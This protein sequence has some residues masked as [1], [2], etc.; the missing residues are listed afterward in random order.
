MWKAKCAGYPA[1]VVRS[2]LNCVEYG[3]E[4][5]GHNIKNYLES[6]NHCDDSRMWTQWEPERR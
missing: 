4:N 1:A 5:A 6:D 3:E 2:L